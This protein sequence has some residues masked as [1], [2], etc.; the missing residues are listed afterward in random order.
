MLLIFVDMWLLGVP[1]FLATNIVI[2]LARVV[3]G[4]KRKRIKHFPT[5]QRGQTK[6]I[7]DTEGRQVSSTRRLRGATRWASP[8]S[9]TTSSAFSVSAYKSA[10]T[11]Y[12]YSL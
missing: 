8:A 3:Q 6:T 1:A 12:E 5:I 2:G 9:R 4:K 11:A 7:C 10:Q